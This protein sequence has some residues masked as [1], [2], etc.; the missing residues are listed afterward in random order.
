LPTK[1]A[2]PERASTA[3]GLFWATSPKVEEN[4]LLG[5][6][7]MEEGIRCFDNEA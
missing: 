3:L 4:P 5:P 7:I 1:C 6:A 2:R